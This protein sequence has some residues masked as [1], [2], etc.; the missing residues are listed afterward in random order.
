MRASGRVGIGNAGWQAARSGGGARRM[1]WVEENTAR[2]ASI[3]G[4]K[5]PSLNTMFHSRD[6]RKGE[7]TCCSAREMYV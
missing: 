1:L 3:W 7:T 6:V 5:V 2:M 4:S